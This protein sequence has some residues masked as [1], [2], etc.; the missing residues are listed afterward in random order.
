[1]NQI[2]ENIDCIISNLYTKNKKKKNVFGEKSYSEARL[3]IS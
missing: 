3:E 2:I 1:M